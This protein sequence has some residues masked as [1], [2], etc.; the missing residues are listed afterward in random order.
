M[1]KKISIPLYKYI[2][3]MIIRF[4]VVPE[5]EELGFI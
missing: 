2:Y 1:K 5:K 3:Y 4:M